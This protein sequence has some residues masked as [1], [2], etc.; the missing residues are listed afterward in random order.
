MSR[1]TCYEQMTIEERFASS[2]IRFG[3]SYPI[4]LLG[5]LLMPALAAQQK[6][7]SSPPISIENGKKL[8]AEH[9][10]GCHGA[11]TQGTDR[12]PSLEG[13]RRLR[14]RSTGQLRTLIQQG[15]PASGMPAFD[16]PIQQLDAIAGFVH[17]L[18]SSAAENVA[19]GNPSEGEQMFF[20]KT[21]G[22]SQRCAVR[23]LIALILPLLTLLAVC[24]C[25]TVSTISPFYTNFRP[26]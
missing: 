10:A 16:L 9:C 4:L 20:G 3:T 21:Q 6:S 26:R 17:S 1:Q 15:I 25:F 22:T 7:S 12:A 11:D 14:Q 8:Y 5:L 13:N 18:N 2:R 24:V 19:P 23:R